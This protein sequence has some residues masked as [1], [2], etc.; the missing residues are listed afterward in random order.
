[1]ICCHFSNDVVVPFGSKF[2][3][4]WSLVKKCHPFIIRH[5]R[6]N[7]ANF[8]IVIIIAIYSCFSLLCS[9][10]KSYHEKKLDSHFETGGPKLSYILLLHIFKVY[11]IA[12]PL[13]SSASLLLT[14]KELVY[15]TLIALYCMKMLIHFSSRH[16]LLSIIVLNRDCSLQGNVGAGLVGGKCRF[17]WFNNGNW[18][19]EIR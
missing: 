10:G 18:L 11:C 6:N 8:S 17:L 1:M 19:I 7:I 13:R 16:T 9:T 3:V 15:Y 4:E 12:E 2:P 5:G 14:W